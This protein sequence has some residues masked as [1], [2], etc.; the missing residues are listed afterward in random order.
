M[1][2][3]IED[4]IVLAKPIGGTESGYLSLERGQ[5]GVHKFDCFMAHSAQEDDHL[6]EKYK[7]K[8]KFG[9][10]ILYRSN[11]ILISLMPWN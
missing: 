6:Y 1:R 9:A 8:K 3:H 5:Q 7:K 2:E 11:K 10:E 4:K